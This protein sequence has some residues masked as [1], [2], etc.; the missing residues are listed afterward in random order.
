M[1]I[2]GLG[3]DTAG[4]MLLLPRLL[5]LCREA[6]SLYASGR[7][8][9]GL[10]REA[11]V[12]GPISVLL[13]DEQDALA[14]LGERTAGGIH[15]VDTGRDPSGANRELAMDH[16]AIM[17]SGSPDPTTITSQTVGSICG[18]ILYY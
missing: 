12:L 17:H 8:L 18:S 7:L 2:S 6:R 16:L 5:L 15:S 4:A 13:V 9:E 10:D 11:G 14:G 1:C 3:A